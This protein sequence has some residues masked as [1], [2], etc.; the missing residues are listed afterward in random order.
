MTKASSFLLASLFAMISMQQGAAFTGVS[1][2]RASSTRLWAED[3][4]ALEGEGK[5][6]LKVRGFVSVGRRNG[7]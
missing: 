4:V 7:S 5:I 6:N 3:Y 1:L 2:Q